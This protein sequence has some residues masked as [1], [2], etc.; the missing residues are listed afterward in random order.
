MFNAKPG[1]PCIHSLSQFIHLCRLLKRAAASFFFFFFVWKYKYCTHYIRLLE[2]GK[3]AP[4]PTRFSS[5]RLCSC[6]WV[7]WVGEA[8]DHHISTNPHNQLMACSV[9]VGVTKPRARQVKWLP[10]A[11][12]TDSKYK[13][14]NSEIQQPIC[15][16]R[17]DLSLLF[18]A[19]F[20]NPS[21]YKAYK[22]KVVLLSRFSAKTQTKISA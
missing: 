5:R 12:K 3:K 18:L 20:S 11:W 6:C 19:F 17:Q 1:H 15:Q 9:R 8:W 16:F 21:V 7:E 22:G 14:N 4:R 2:V 10:A 13:Q